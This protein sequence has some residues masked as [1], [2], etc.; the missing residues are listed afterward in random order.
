MTRARDRIYWSSATNYVPIKIWTSTQTFTPEERLF[1]TSPD[2]Q[3][4]N[5]LLSGN[6]LALPEYHAQICTF[7]KTPSQAPAAPAP[8]APAAPWISGKSGTTQQVLTL[9]QAKI[10]TPARTILTPG[11]LSTLSPSSQPKKTGTEGSYTWPEAR[12]RL[13]SSIRGSMKKLFPG[14]I[15]SKLLNSLASRPTAHFYVGADWA[16]A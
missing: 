3:E 16:P 4:Q 6:P 13:D 10:P 2:P 11:P 7:H 14:R 12:L 5:L 1:W 9:S 8:S 15:S